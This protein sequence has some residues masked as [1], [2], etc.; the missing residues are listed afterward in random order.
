MARRG[1]PPHPDVLT[2]REWEV[3][4]LLREGLSNEEVAEQLG[5]SLAGAKYH[6]SEILG[7][8]GVESREEAARWQPGARSW[9]ALAAAPI[10]A[11]WRKIN[12]GPLAAAAA[13]GVA[14]LA[15][16][17]IALLVW[18]LLRTN[19]GGNGNGSA[20]LAPAETPQAL[21]EI[22]GRIDS[23]SPDRLVLQDLEGHLVNVRIEH[24]E[25][26]EAQFCA[27]PENV[28]RVLSEAALAP[29]EDVCVF[30]H[31]MRSG[32]FVV[33]LAQLKAQCYAVPVATPTAP[34]P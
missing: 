4:A 3:L 12:S 1:R 23:I 27:V 32:E 25:G 5:I 11:A 22:G 28:C 33:W 16:A 17:G 30:A 31:L 24:A 2:P 14:A 8:L 20:A 26:P 6:V 10:G 19:G 13:V 18:G 15:A 9:W 34:R 21:V 7:K 29:G